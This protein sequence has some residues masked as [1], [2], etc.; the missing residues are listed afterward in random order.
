MKARLSDRYTGYI[1]EILT[2]FLKFKWNKVL[3]FDN[4]SKSQERRKYL[5]KV[6]SQMKEK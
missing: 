5:I 2:Q 3:L 1:K 6:C 4:K